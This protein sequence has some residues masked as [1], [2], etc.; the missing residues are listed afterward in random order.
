[1]AKKD[2]K[3]YIVID[4]GEPDCPILCD[5]AEEGLE[6]IGEWDGDEFELDVYVF[7]GSV[8]VKHGV[9]IVSGKFPS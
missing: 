3:K 9:R 4:R 7:S 1:M 6:Q 2:A 5:S 8:K